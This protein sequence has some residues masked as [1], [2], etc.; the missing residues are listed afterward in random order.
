MK[1]T[2]Y[3]TDANGVYLFPQIANELALAPGLF[4][5]PY[6]AYEDEPPQAPEGMLARRTSD[7]WELAEDHRRASLWLVGSGESY[8]LG[9]DVDIDGE[10]RSYPGIG[11]IPEWLT[12]TA[13]VP[14]SDGDA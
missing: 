8:T 3:Q 6:G 10:T 1:K 4:N 13:P 9:A 2:V 7:A 12:N 11:P 5:V 14:P